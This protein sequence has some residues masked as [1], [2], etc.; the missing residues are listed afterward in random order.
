MTIRESIREQRK[1]IKNRSPREQLA[2]YWEY[3]GLKAIGILAAIALVV[4]FIVSMVT[5]K[6]Y[7][8]TGVFF[9]SSPGSNEQTYLADFAQAAGIDTEKYELTV[10]PYPDI[11]MDQQITNEIY[12]SMQAFTAM[13]A[14]NTVDC[15]AGNRELFLYYSYLGYTTD[16]RSVLTAQELSVLEPYLYYVDGKLIEQQEEND[17]GLAFAYGQSPDPTQPLLMEDPIPV[18]IS[19]GA[20]SQAF[21]ETYPFAP[22]DAAIGICASTEHLEN[23][24]AFLRYCFAG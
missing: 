19:V 13:V 17:E 9:G 8:F 22:Q 11:P 10:R 12:Q 21:S 2:Y 3:Y 5:Q 20:A 16:L 15:F 23:A 6:E 7:A 1:A 24:L 18:G 4:A 14:A